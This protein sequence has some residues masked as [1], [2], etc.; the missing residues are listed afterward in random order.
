MFIND[1]VLHSGWASPLFRRA[2]KKKRRGERK[3]EEGQEEKEESRGMVNSRNTQSALHGV[4]ISPL[5]AL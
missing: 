2:V 3:E 4:D 1:P 5:S